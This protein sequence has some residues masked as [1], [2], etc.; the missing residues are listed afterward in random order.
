MIQNL[1]KRPRRNRK[2][3][4]IRNLVQENYI[5]AHDVVAPFFLVEGK[6]M[7]YP[8][9][10][11][12][13]N[14]LLSSDEILK[15]AEELTKLGIQALI[16][17]PVVSPHL[18]DAQGSYALNKNN[19]LFLAAK[20]IKK[21]FPNLCIIADIALDAYTSHGHDGLVSAEGQILNDETAQVLADMSVLC[22]H[23]GIDI[24]APSDM[25]DGRIRMIRETLDKEGLE[26]VNLMSLTA[27]YAS[28][29]YVPYRDALQSAPRFGDKKS[30]QLNPANIREALIE[31]KLDEEEGADFLVVKP[32]TLYLDVIQ[33][34]KANTNLPVVTYHVTGEY[35]MLKAAAQ[36]KWI[37]FD[38]ALH[39]TLLSIKRAGADIIITWGA[40]EIA[41]QLKNLSS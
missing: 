9:A 31:A 10:S 19:H 34:I 12:P 23:S 8:L 18:K 24:I 17:Y 14:F 40:K 21:Y 32:A 4:A 6:Q 39:E 15:E 16:L 11:L 35:S 26:Y 33:A 13:N 20:E 29:F 3:A 41:T 25:M 37:D 30:Y 22:G 7:R 28:S 38:R 2:N 27:K 1:L 36:N 5:T